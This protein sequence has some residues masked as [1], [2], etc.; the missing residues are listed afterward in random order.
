MLLTPASGEVIEAKLAS[1]VLV[2]LLYKTPR[3]GEVWSERSGSWRATLAYDG[4]FDQSF[5]P[6][7]ELSP[8]QRMLDFDAP[9]RNTSLSQAAVSQW[10]ERR[11]ER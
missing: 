7:P 11:F 3:C 5:M 10:L 2:S 1:D 9:I 4:I 8:Q 6:R